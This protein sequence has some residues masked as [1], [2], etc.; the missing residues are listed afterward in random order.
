M[1]PL[2]A[3]FRPILLSL[4]LVWCVPVWAGGIIGAD[5]IAE[6]AAVV[7]STTALNPLVTSTINQLQSNFVEGVMGAAGLALYA[8]VISILANVVEVMTV[9]VTNATDATISTTAANNAILSAGLGFPAALLGTGAALIAVPLVTPPVVAGLVALGVVA[10]TAVATTAA[11]A[12][13]GA[14]VGIAIGVAADMAANAAATA[15][16]ASEGK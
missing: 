15:M 16:S 1:K 2:V 9:I 8:P 12:V 6:P 3:L 11:A 10:S 7:A 13:V 5:D 4:A 14:T